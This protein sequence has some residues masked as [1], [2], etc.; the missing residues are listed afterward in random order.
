MEFLHA[1]V[2]KVLQGIEKKSTISEHE[3]LKASMLKHIIQLRELLKWE[4]N[5]YEVSLINS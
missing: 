2:S 3:P 1:E 4:K 5:E